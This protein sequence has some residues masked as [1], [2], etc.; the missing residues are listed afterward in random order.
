[1]TMLPPD[2]QHDA[3]DSIEPRND[4]IRS[5]TEMVAEAHSN[6]SEPNRLMAVMSLMPHINPSASPG[7]ILEVIKGNQTTQIKAARILMISHPHRRESYWEWFRGKMPFETF[8]SHTS[9]AFMEEYED[10][11]YAE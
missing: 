1:M 11:H 10:F 8:W 5:F 7:D 9:Q 6:G 2:L 4:R 3:V